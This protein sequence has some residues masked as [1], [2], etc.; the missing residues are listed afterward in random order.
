VTASNRLIAS[1]TAALACALVT[2]AAHADIGVTGSSTP[3]TYTRG[4]INSYLLDLNIISNAFG[5]A[6]ALTFALP[7]GVTISAVR[8]R[9][10][11]SFCNDIYPLVNGMGTNDGGWYQLGYPVLDGCGSFSGSPDPGEFQ[12]VIVDVDVPADYTGDLPLVVNVLGDGNGEFAAAAG[13]ELDGSAFGL[14]TRSQ[15]YAAILDGGV[16]RQL[17]VEPDPLL[18]TV[19]SADSVLNAL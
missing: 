6:D 10:T 3:T 9:N 13:L 15:R 16:V 11:F 1:L 4:A 5:G 18:V 19:S 12:I 14:G 8:K 2:N 7:P 17:M